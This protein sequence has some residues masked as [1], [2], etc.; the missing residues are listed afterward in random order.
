LRLSFLLKIRSRKSHVRGRAPDAFINYSRSPPRASVVPYTHNTQRWCTIYILRICLRSC[1]IVL[2]YLSSIFF[3]F[4]YFF[5]S[6][7]PLEH[8][9]THRGAYN[10]DTYIPMYNSGAFAVSCARKNIRFFP[11][12]V[13]ILIRPRRQY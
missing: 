6:S 11:S 7:E 3:F 5:L 10:I 9:A 12:Y 8:K 2:L 13:Y 4:F 1:I